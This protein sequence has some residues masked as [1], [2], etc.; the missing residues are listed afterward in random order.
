MRALCRPRPPRRDL[1]G[2]AALIVALAAAKA[3]AQPARDP[4]VAQALFEDGKALMQQGKY[5]EACPKL[6]ESQ[7]LDPGGGTIL[8]LA[9]CHEGAGKTASAWAAFNEA[10]AEARKDKR[11]ERENAALEHIRALEP[12]LTKVRIL[13][14]A[15]VEGLEIRRDGAAVGR[16]QWSTAVPIDP[17]T[18]AFE[19]RAPRKK[20]WS[21]S[22]KLE[23][24]GVVEVRVPALED[25]ASASAAPPVGGPKAAP[26]QPEDR[27]GGDSSRT[28]WALIAG[29]VGIAGLVGGTAFGLSA[30][31][32]WRDAERACPNGVCK[33][34]S[35]VQAGEDAGKTAD[36]STAF[37]VVGGLGVTTAAVL[38]LT[39]PGARKPDKDESS[40]R[41]TP[42]VG[43]AGAGLGVGGAL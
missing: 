27:D 26:P 22:V 28:T 12:R 40:L 23:G 25:D 24:A 14:G 36:L 7:R 41:F 2:A 4:A 32:K 29:G 8:A 20:T 42:Y 17:G 31:S 37:F 18:H 39:A 35:S 6:A 5:P 3:H 38:F 43:P 34:A 13:V 16:P 9:L 19:A 15:D 10:L 33:A 21:A 30:S 11:T 1:R